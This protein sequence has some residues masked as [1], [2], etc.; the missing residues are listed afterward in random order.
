[1]KAPEVFPRGGSPG[2]SLSGIDA[3]VLALVERGEEH[4]L[5]QQAGQT[6]KLSRQ[7]NAK[8]R[9]ELGI[10]E[11]SNLHA[12]LNS[13]TTQCTLIVGFA[14]AGVG[15]DTLSSLASDQDQFCIYKTER[16]Q[17]LGV[18]FILVTIITIFF[19]MTVLA[20]AQTIIAESNSRIFDYDEVGGAHQVVIMTALLMHGERSGT[21]K[22][23]FV[24]ARRHCVMRI[25]PGRPS[26]A[27]HSC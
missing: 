22:H 13:M 5:R 16:A 19:S 10:T 9:I 26:G 15:S 17:A 4:L 8:G 3:D 12:Q 23:S 24:Q 21:K 14:L 18:T 7:M 1:M 6:F 11:L 2:V 27:G 20:S 25:T